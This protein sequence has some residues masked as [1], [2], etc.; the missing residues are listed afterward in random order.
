M[1]KTRAMPR[2]CFS[3]MPFSINST[4]P[5]LLLSQHWTSQQL[6]KKKA[7]PVAL[8]QNKITQPIVVVSLLLIKMCIGESAVQ[9]AMDCKSPRFHL[10]FICSTISF[11]SRLTSAISINETHIPKGQFNVSVFLNIF[12][13]N[14]VFTA[15]IMAGLRLYVI[16]AN[17]L[18]GAL[19]FLFP[20]NHCA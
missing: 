12:T 13:L 2:P 8:F 18:P 9:N 17:F 4:A 1:D 11:C 14:P 20:P 7:S 19:L 10:E 16:S 3:I 15:R 6:Q 5:S